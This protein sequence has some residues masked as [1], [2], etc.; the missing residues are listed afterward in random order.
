MEKVCPELW[1][2]REIGERRKSLW[3]SL[4]DSDSRDF[5]FYSEAFL[6]RQMIKIP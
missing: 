1:E 3:K 6:R 4:K 2:Y 5:K